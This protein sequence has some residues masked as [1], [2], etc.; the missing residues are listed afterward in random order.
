MPS[1]VWNAAWAN[2]DDTGWSIQSDTIDV[3]AGSITVTRDDGTDM[4]VTVTNLEP[5]YGSTYAVSI[6]PVGWAKEDG[7]TYTV[8]VT[9]ASQPITYDVSPVDCSQY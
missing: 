1:A 9:G 8:S 7:R 2:L 6:L 5:Y 4:P 3:R